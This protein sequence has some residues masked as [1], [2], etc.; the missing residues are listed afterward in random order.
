MK[1]ARHKIARATAISVTSSVDAKLL[2]KQGYV[3]KIFVSDSFYLN[4]RLAPDEHVAYVTPPETM[5]IVPTLTWFFH[6]GVKRFANKRQELCFSS[7]LR[8]ISWFIK[9]TANNF[10]FKMY[11]FAMNT[12]GQHDQD[13]FYPVLNPP[14]FNNVVTKEVLLVFKW[15]QVL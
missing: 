3:N 8:I 6:T 5:F 9:L 2:L 14:Y 7:F 15:Q 12:M 1:F 11:S 4:K 13:I 10:T